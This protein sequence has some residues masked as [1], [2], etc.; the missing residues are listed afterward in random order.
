MTFDN[1]SDQF[2]MR[3]FVAS[4]GDIPLPLSILQDEGIADQEAIDAETEESQ[5]PRIYPYLAR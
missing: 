2:E 3:E 5:Q 1:S 4:L